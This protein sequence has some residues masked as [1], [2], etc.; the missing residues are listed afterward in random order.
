MNII[1][2]NEL[3]GLMMIPLFVDWHIRRCNAK[4][5]RER[6]TTII[7]GAGEG[8]RVFGLC[9]ADFQRGN[10][11]GGTNYDLEWDDFDAFEFAKEH[12]P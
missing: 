4:G 12:T 7:S 5:C 10:M 6:P 3:G 9:E 8:I 11:E 1:R 2:D